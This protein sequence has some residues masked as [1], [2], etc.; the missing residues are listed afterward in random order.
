MILGLGIDSWITIATLVALMAALLFTRLRTDVVFWGV[1]GILFVTGVLDKSEAFSGLINSSVIIVGVMFV[2]VTG[3]SR[4]GVLL[5]MTKHILG[6]PKSPVQI[7]LRLMLSV[8]LLSPFVNN[9]SVVALFV[10]GVKLWSRK[11]GITPSKLLIPMSYAGGMGGPMAAIATPTALLMCGM[12]EQQTSQSLSIFVSTIP[13]L[14]C[15]AVSMLVLILCRGLL[16]DT[17]N[18]E[19]AFENTGDYTVEMLVTSNNPH[20][21]KTVGELGLNQIRAGS[22]VELIHFDNYRLVS[23][24]NN[25]EPLMGGDRLIFSGQIDDLLELAR[26][27]GFV[28]S[29]HPVFCIN[30]V[31]SPRRLRTAYICF[32]SNL[33]EKRLSDTTFEHDNNMTLVAVS[34]K[35]VHINEP[36]REVV[37]HAGDSL[38]FASPPRSKVNTDALKSQLQFF[39]S[40]EIPVVG[41]KPL[42]STLILVGMVLLAT[43]GV[44]S[45]LQSAFIAAGAMLVFGCCSP[46]QAMNAINWKILISLGGGLALGTALQKTGLAN[47]VAMGVLDFCGGQPLLVM[48]ALC[49]I[50]A[51]VTEFVS[52]S[53]AIALMFPIVYEAAVDMGCNP[54]PF[55]IALL[56]AVNDAFLTPISS[57]LNLLVYG[58]G[59]YRATD[60][61]RIGLPVKIAYLTTAI[62]TIFLLYD[63]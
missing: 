47:Q 18:P 11:L 28:S 51:I 8:G 20:I 38:L 27:M 53:S 46:T 4:T 25:D 42:I 61:L 15:F 58:P 45:L 41:M 50:A 49:L 29:D 52:N 33:I 3:L 21:S 7:L 34:R 62:I 36:P 1:I 14:A 40:P 44:M 31:R 43:T 17:S 57:P 19:A 13:A 5:W 12:Y 30:D 24:V 10:G 48:I 54:L 23:P 6:N 2:I 32:G 56:L 35:G 22:L 9:T 39:D 60:Y 37:L 59:G 63:I 26:E 16:P 55:V